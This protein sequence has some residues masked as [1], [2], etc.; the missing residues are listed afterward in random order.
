MVDLPPEGL[1]QGLMGLGFGIGLVLGSGLNGLGVSGFR[2]EG[3]G[4]WL[5]R[6]RVQSL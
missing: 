1:L 2:V 3:S 4:L 5:R 6:V